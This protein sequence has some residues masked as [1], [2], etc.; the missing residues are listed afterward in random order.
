MRRSGLLP[1]LCLS[2]LPTVR[3]RVREHQGRKNSRFTNDS[4]LLKFLSSFPASL[5]LFTFPSSNI[6]PMHP[7]CPGILRA[8]SGRGMTKCASS[9]LPR[10]RMLPLPSQPLLCITSH[11]SGKDGVVA[12]RMERP[13]AL[14]SLVYMHT[15][16]SQGPHCR[17][18]TLS[19]PSL[20]FGHRDLVGTGN[21]WDCF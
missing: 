11:P 20:V 2:L 14:L 7:F 3:F 8:F 17:G 4:A 1:E 9:I 16:V 19:L 21:R 6:C 10:T 12:T 5:E 15:P 13:K 18:T